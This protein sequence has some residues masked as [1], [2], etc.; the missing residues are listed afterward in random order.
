MAMSDALPVTGVVPVSA[1]A[2]E[3][4]AEL[5]KL[6]TMEPKARD[7][8]SQ[9][10]WCGAIPDFYFGAGV[11]DVFA[12]FLAQIKPARA[13]RQMNISGSS[14][15]TFHLPISLLRTVPIQRMP[16]KVTSVKCGSG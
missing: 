9:F 3:D 4:D 12:V 14:Q 13:S 5:Q 2:G 15:A 1:M 10:D 8:I 16:W 7:Y 6:R 11:G